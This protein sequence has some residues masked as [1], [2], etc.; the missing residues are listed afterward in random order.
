[1]NADGPVLVAIMGP[2]GSGKS[3]LA[4]AL[5]ER[6]DAQL[7]NAD[8][9][10]VYIGLDIGTNKPQIRGDYRLLDLKAADQ[11]YGV[12]EYVLDVAAVLAEKFAAGRSVVVV[13]GTG[14]YIRAL[15]EEYT[16][17]LGS[18][19]QGLRDELSSLSL[20]EMLERL[21]A[22][23]STH[24]L[25]RSNRRRVQRALER[26]LQPTVPISFSIPGFRK[27]KFGIHTPV[28]TLDVQLAIRT[29]RLLRSGWIEEVEGL[30]KAGLSPQFASF[31]AI[32]YAEISRFL[33]GAFS[34]EE[35]LDQ[36]QL[37]TRQY[38]KRQRAWMRSEPNLI[39]LHRDSPTPPTVSEIE[40]ML[41]QIG[42]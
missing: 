6:L 3:A 22:I 19:D 41:Q 9:F 18:P 32:G 27:A 40:S 28:E 29:E 4:E 26:A 11:S 20:P 2:T 24:D 37:Q 39:P 8:A 42:R 12:G 21:D 5:A 1:M 17:L 16:D 7:V 34:F 14:L 25:D 35:L 30:L 33:D 36:V 13:G 31:K 23:A 15:F 10:Q 38:A